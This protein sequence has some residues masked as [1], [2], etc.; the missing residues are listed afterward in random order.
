MG[1]DSVVQLVMWIGVILIIPVCYRFCYAASSLL[2]RRLFPTRM[3]EFQFSDENTG[4]KKSLTI[5]V[6]RNKSEL[7]VNLIDEAI[8]E[9]S[10]RK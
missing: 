7:L 4:L 8:Q 5:K 3:F 1:N 6:P 9:Q 10:K 2:W